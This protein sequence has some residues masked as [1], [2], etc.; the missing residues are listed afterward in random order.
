MGLT[1]FS[2]ENIRKIYAVRE[3]L[4]RIRMMRQ[5]LQDV[6]LANIR[7]PKNVI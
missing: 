1:A 3:F 7:G 5:N 4:S 2:S 6:R